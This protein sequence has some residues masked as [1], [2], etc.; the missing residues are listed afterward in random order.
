MDSKVLLSYKNNNKHV[1]GNGM[2]YDWDKLAMFL[3]QL[4]YMM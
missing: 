4:Q 3:L 1:S 2:Q